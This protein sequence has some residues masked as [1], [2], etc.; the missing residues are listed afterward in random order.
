MTS[1]SNGIAAALRDRGVA[2]P[3]ATLAAESGVTVFGIAFRQWLAEGET[4][5]LAEIQRDVLDQLRSVTQSTA[6]ATPAAENL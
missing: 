4:R 6:G 1:L 3:Q 5:S 2:E